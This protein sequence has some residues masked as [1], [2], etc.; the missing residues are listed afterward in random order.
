MDAKTFIREGRSEL[1]WDL[2]P[3]LW[4]GNI[5]DENESLFYVSENGDFSWFTATIFEKK[6][7]LEHTWR[8]K[9]DST[10]EAMAD[11]QQWYNNFLIQREQEALHGA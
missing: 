6:Y 11:C 2:G 5:L 8:S 4:Q 9:F 10:R 1:V 7:N 3:I